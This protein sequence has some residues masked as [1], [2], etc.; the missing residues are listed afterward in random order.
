M[1][2]IFDI[3]EKKKEELGLQGVTAKKMTPDELDFVRA[4]KYVNDLPPQF[5]ELLK[6]NSFNVGKFKLGKNHIIELEKYIYNTRIVIEIVGDENKAVQKVTY[7]AFDNYTVTAYI[8]EI[9]KAKG[10]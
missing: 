6:D 2:S 4:K 5:M 9:L 10:E 3:L 8:R 7:Y 1:N